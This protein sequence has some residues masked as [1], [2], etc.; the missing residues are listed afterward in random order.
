MGAED[1]IFSPDGRQLLLVNGTRLAVVSAETWEPVK[2]PAGGKPVFS[3]FAFQQ[4]GALL[5][6][7]DGHEVLVWNT[8]NGRLT[9]RLQC[10][11]HSLSV[12]TLLFHPDDHHLV[13]GDGKQF[14]GWDLN[15][16]KSGLVSSPPIL[17]STSPFLQW[18]DMPEVLLAFSMGFTEDG[19]IAL[20]TRQK[21]AWLVNLN[22][23]PIQKPL[24]SREITLEGLGEEDWLCSCAL[25]PKADWMAVAANHNLRIYKL[26]PDSFEKEIRLTETGDAVA[27]SVNGRWCV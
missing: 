18:P 10:P 5:A 22:S 16:I 27:F 23:D 1:V 15:A 2:Q 9:A 20:V 19:S 26:N 3:M 24:H 13:A 21:R 25:S 14:W 11:A 12:V 4:K 7:T 8:I 17:A 6:T